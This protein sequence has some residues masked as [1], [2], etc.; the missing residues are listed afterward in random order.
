MWTLNSSLRRQSYVP[1]WPFGIRRNGVVS[2]S[3]LAN[4][5][6]PTWPTQ[7]EAVRSFGALSI[8]V[9]AKTTAPT[10]IREMDMKCYQ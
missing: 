10:Q 5:M 1:K 6:D 3:T 2:L 9:A 7:S 4:M 8:G